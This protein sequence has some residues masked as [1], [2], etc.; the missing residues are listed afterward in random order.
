MESDRDTGSISRRGF[1]QYMAMFAVGGRTLLTSRDGR[2]A[3]S[4]AKEAGDASSAARNR[5]PHCT[6]RDRP[7]VFRRNPQV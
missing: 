6:K 7:A 4:A 5:T 1:I 3:I 2:A